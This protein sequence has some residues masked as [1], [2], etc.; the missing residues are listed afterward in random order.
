MWAKRRVPAIGGRSG[1][2]GCGILFA[3]GS[4]FR[5]RAERARRARARVLPHLTAARETGAPVGRM[6]ISSSRT[7]L[8]RACVLRPRVAVELFDPAGDL[9]CVPCANMQRR[10]LVQ[11]WQRV[12]HAFAGRRAQLLAKSRAPVF[13]LFLRLQASKEAGR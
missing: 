5:D 6:R 1:G 4:K 2:E 10:P 11:Q 9:W 13:V 7:T 12:S 8:M 3:A